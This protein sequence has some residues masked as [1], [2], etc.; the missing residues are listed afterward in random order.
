[1]KVTNPLGTI[2]GFAERFQ[3][4]PAGSNALCFAPIW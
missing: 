2:N 3:H 1:V 4:C